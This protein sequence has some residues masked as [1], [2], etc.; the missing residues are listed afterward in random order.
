MGRQAD[1]AQRAESLYRA[2]V[3]R[4]NFL[5]QDRSELLFASKECSR[6]MSMPCN[7]DWPAL[8]RIGRF[9]KGTPRVVT[10]YEWQDMPTRISAYTDSNWAGCRLTRKSTSGAAFLHGKHLVKACS[11]TQSNIALS[12]AEAELYATVSAASEALG[13]KA[14]AKDFGTHLETDLHV[15]ASAAIGIAQRKGLGKLRHLDTQAL[16]IQD[17]VR[18]KRVSVEKVLGSENPADLMTKHLDGQ[19]LVKCL[20]K[21]GGQ[22]RQGRA[23]V[24]PNLV[25]KV[26]VS[27]LNEDKVYGP[28]VPLEAARS[29][30]S[31]APPGGTRPKVRFLMTPSQLALEKRVRVASWLSR[32]E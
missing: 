4:V 20:K 27:A 14:M 1:G 22:V 9:L 8:K 28:V 21:L 24:A 17:A 30:P 26:E 31:S 6:H 19:D 12:S 10:L 11:R 2:I 13:L 5:A 25:E 16:W 32:R 23:K 3:A 29:R 7:G 15:D 18:C